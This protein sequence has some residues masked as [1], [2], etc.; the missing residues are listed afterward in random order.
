MY[1]NLKLYRM[2][3]GEL[4]VADEKTEQDNYIWVTRPHSIIEQEGKV[5]LQPS[6]PHEED[7]Q[8]SIN[9]DMV[10]LSTEAPENI[11]TGYQQ[12]L[13]NIVIPNPNT[14]DNITPLSASMRK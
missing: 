8:V 13:S 10:V 11:C 7:K 9:K 2:S 6:I 1:D 14:S 4:I 3:N 12:A 5:M